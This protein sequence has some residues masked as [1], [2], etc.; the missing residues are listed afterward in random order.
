[1]DMLEEARVAALMQRARLHRHDA[2]PAQLALELITIR[3]ARALGLDDRIGSLE[4]GK[5]ADL[6]AFPL[7]GAAAAP[8][9]DVVT[10]AIFSLGGTRAS[11]VMVDGVELVRDGRIQR[12]VPTAREVEQIASALVR[13]RGR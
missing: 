8:L 3:G 2:I 11:T 5:A 7:D 13:W 12:S 1:M 4:K 6:A 9:G 10:A